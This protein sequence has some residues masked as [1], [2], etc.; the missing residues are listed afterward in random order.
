MEKKYPV[1]G[2][3][4]SKAIVT[5]DRYRDLYKRSVEDPRSFWA[6]RAEEF[7][8][9]EKKWDDV[10]SYDYDSANI[11]WFEGGQLSLSR[12]PCT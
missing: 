4:A 7:L 12:G 1:T 6:S 10:C 11:K 8:V 5:K 3:L 2:E 9:W